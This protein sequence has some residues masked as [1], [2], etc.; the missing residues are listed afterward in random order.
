MCIGRKHFSSWMAAHSCFLL[1]NNN[2]IRC[3]PAVSC[4]CV[5]GRRSRLVRQ[6]RLRTNWKWF[7]SR[8]K[9]NQPTECSALWRR[10]Q[11]EPNLIIATPAG[12]RHRL[13]NHLSIVDSTP[14]NSHNRPS[15]D[16]LFCDHLH[17]CSFTKVFTIE[18]TCFWSLP[19]TVFLVDA[20][21][22]LFFSPALLARPTMSA[23]CK[24]TKSIGV[25]VT[26]TI[27]SFVLSSWTR[28]D[29]GWRFLWVQ[30][31]RVCKV[32]VMSIVLMT[33]FGSFSWLPSST[34][35]VLIRHGPSTSP[36]WTRWLRGRRLHWRRS[37]LSLYLSIGPFWASLI[38]KI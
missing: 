38:S 14:E 6:I 2:Q 7:W 33:C 30:R 27:F 23:E 11:S 25:C 37:L 28:R 17:I 20:S 22:N 10:H 9:I 18:L 16:Q 3:V 29:S 4:E 31:L 21:I 35:C 13:S 34:V 24:Q 19:G 5:C 26:A 15:A 36:Q 8:D 12:L 32:M 1:N